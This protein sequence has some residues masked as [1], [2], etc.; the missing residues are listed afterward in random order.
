[1][2]S[3]VDELG[4]ILHPS[5]MINLLVGNQHYSIYA[6]EFLG[7]QNMNIHLNI[8]KLVERP[9]WLAGMALDGMNNVYPWVA[10]DR[11]AK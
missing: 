1:M 3:K 4:E 5:R 11:F 7:V 2:D 6:H 9:Y 10:L 8:P